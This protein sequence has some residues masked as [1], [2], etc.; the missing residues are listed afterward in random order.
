MENRK[1]PEYCLLGIVLNF[2]EYFEQI[3]KN[4]NIFQSRVCNEL[5]SI[6][7][8]EKKG[9]NK[10]TLLET[11]KT[12]GM[13]D[14]SDFYEVYQS[15][16]DESHFKIYYEYVMVNYVRQKLFQNANE[17]YKKKIKTIDEIKD[18]L[19]NLILKLDI[20]T[21]NDNI[22]SKQIIKEM[23][24][25]QSV[26][27][28]ESEIPYIDKYGGYES[29]DYVI[30]AARSSVGKTSFALNLIRMQ[31]LR[32]MKIGLFSL[33]VRPDRIM[34]SLWCIQAGLSEWRL[35]MKQLTEEEKMKYSN[36]FEPFYNG[37]LVF[38]R[39]FNINDMARKVKK[40][41][42]ENNI[43]MVY[44]DYLGFISGGE[45]KSKYE[46]VG[47]ISKKLKRIAFD[48][49]IPVICLAQLNRECVKADREPKVSDLR[50]SGEIEQDA[51]VIILLSEK[52]VDEQFQA[53]LTVNIAKNRNNPTG[54]INA[55]FN[56]NLRKITF[57]G[58]T[59]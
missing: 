35:K 58:G 14:E 27:L 29:T 36:S 18:D 25:L 40:M 55:F 51:D 26:K 33:E 42:K 34:Q 2:P 16:Y 7:E 52:S 45:G 32:K 15:E 19:Q 3:K 13:I 39:T 44:I 6:L 11:I 22:T 1:N 30:I 57:N 12:K 54:K 46:Q 23:A 53:L 10:Q 20:G 43:Q 41:V 17:I 24:N 47:D 31:L 59:K 28:V 37:N 50:D 9:F 8:S 49:G 5:Y 21:D 56:K 38:G 48:N 4:G